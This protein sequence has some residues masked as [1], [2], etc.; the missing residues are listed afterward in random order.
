MLVNRFN[1]YGA[2]YKEQ[3]VFVV[4]TFN[5]TKNANTVMERFIRTYK[6]TLTARTV[7]TI[8]K[9]QEHGTIL[10]RNKGNSGRLITKRTAENALATVRDLKDC[11]LCKMGHHVTE[12]SVLRTF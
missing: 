12:L 3:I 6:R 4:R 2:Y 9:F 8:L 1:N 5:E 11:G 10:N 7:R